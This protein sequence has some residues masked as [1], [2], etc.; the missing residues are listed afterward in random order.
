MIRTFLP[1]AALIVALASAVLA[2]QTSDVHFDAGT[3]GTTIS[4]TVTG[5]E[6]GDYRLGANEGQLLTASIEV[7]ETNGNGTI[8]FNVLPPG[9]DGEAIW[10]GN[11]EADPTAEVTLPEDGTYTLPTYLLGNDRDTGRTVGYQ[12]PVSI[13]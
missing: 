3:S 8:Y 4:G 2:Q 9:S 13:N 12:F 5:N 6:Y 11:M 7:A 1:G 10:I